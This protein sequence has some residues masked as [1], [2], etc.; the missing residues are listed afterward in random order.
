MKKPEPGT[1]PARE[2][3]C[4]P[5][6]SV[7]IAVCERYERSTGSFRNRAR[8]PYTGKTPPNGA[9]KITHISELPA[10]VER[11]NAGIHP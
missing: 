7:F 4:R 3:T 2:Q 8:F 10:L 11:I 6:L 5:D 1:S 9:W